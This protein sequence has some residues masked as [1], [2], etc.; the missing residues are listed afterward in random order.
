M[1]FITLRGVI[2]VL[3]VLLGLFL[4]FY[5]SGIYVFLIGLASILI[6]IFIGIGFKYSLFVML[7]SLWGASNDKN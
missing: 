3:F 7:E 5:C 2:A 1:G 6:G 4:L